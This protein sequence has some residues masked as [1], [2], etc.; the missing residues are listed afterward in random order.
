MAR[1]RVRPVTTLMPTLALLA[2]LTVTACGGQSSASAKSPEAYCRSFY[3]AAAPL[4]DKYTQANANAK[5]DPL[6]GLATILSS[7]GDLATVFDG[8]V[9][10]APSDI[11]ADTVAVRESFRQLQGNL[12]KSAT[13]PL[14]GLASSL[15]AGL[16]SNGSIERVG[17]YLQAH[18]P[19]NS[20][21]ARAYI[22]QPVETAS[23]ASTPTTTTPP[24]SEGPPKAGTTLV[25][26]TAEGAV[27]LVTS[28]THFALMDELINIAEG[29]DTDESRVISFS[30]NG[31]QLAEIKAPELTGKCGAVEADVPGRGSLIV[32]ERVAVHQAEGIKPESSQLTITAWNADGGSNVW[33]HTEASVHGSG[34][35]EPITPTHDGRFALLK[36]G[37][38]TRLLNLGSGAI[39][40]SHGASF[41]IG[42]YPVRESNPEDPA[43]AT[44]QFL[45]P[46]SGRVL[47]HVREI[48]FYTGNTDLAPT[49]TFKTDSDGT[50]PPAGLSEDGQR[51]I[52]LVGERHRLTVFALPSGRVLWSRDWGTKQF[53]GPEPYIYADADG[54]ALVGVT[55]DKT[56]EHQLIAF[57]DSHGQ[58]RWT[59][60]EG[61]VC[62]IT[63]RQVL[64]AVND[65]L[66]TLDT[67]TGRQLS[68]QASSG[69]ECSELEP[70]GRSFS[71]GNEGIGEQRD[72]TVDQVLEP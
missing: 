38:T 19:L 47:G 34:D 70:G 20:A 7:P 61:P 18:C 63:K 12:A 69:N 58:E 22:K 71:T 29:A 31:S 40:S 28:P 64:I 51:L 3:S 17:N 32:T 24:S 59:V 25:S 44:Y 54:L 67:A 35:C 15:V 16:A 37:F 62:G 2:C 60:P 13:D 8:M 68:Y 57:D 53:A 45:D 10:H 14:G 9:S 49:G 27:S 65:Q 11:E 56:E 42:D 36:S 43:T 30:S 48:E 46:A 72:V 23:S 6:M 39:T 5:S 33:S 1:W 52:A 4:H 41:V 50:S 66:A 26:M 21:I 55:N